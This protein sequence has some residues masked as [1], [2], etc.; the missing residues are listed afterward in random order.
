MSVF[1]HV[2]G[3]VLGEFTREKFPG[4]FMDAWRSSVKNADFEKVRTVSALSITVA[5]LHIVKI[6]LTCF[7]HH[8]CGG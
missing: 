2:Q 3:K 1:M 7:C 4:E 5:I 8:M 6:A